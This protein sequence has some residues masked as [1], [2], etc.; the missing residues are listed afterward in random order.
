MIKSADLLTG[1]GGELQIETLR[2]LFLQHAGLSGDGPR[3][4]TSTPGSSAILAQLLPGEFKM[5]RSR[6]EDFLRSLPHATFSR[7]YNPR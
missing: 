5:L 3:D 1:V 6:L 2:D 7:R 4:G